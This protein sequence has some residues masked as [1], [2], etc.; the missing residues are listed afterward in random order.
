MEAERIMIYP[1]TN[2]MRLYVEYELADNNAISSLVCFK[3]SGHTGT[4]FNSN[5]GSLIVKDDFL[6]ELD[7]CTTILPAFYDDLPENGEYDFSNHNSR[8]NDLIFSR[9]KIAIEKGKKIIISHDESTWVE[10]IKAVADPEQIISMDKILIRSDISSRRMHIIE[11]PVLFLINSFQGID[12]N[13]ILFSISRE[14]KRI[15]YKSTIVSSL[16][17]PDLFGVYST[18]HIW[19]MNEI[20]D[21]HKII[22]LNN[23]LK[24]IEQINE[25]G[26]LLVSVPGAT[27]PYSHKAGLTFGS[28]LFM[29]ICGAYPDRCT[30]V[31]PF[32]HYNEK[33]LNEWNTYYKA[34]FG[35]GI[36]DYF[37]TA[38]AILP[39][40]T[41]VYKSSQYL[42]IDEQKVNS[43]IEKQCFS[44]PVFSSTKV[45]AYVD[46]LVEDLS[47][48]T[49]IEIV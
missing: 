14:L 24:E 32:A 4:A 46:K 40:A 15:G 20:S 3:G 16:T 31:L 41:E 47:D 26:I 29:M 34:K 9:I 36:S 48:S 8:V 17:H 19:G 35:I 39:N 30:L 38:R 21:N 11:S 10:K 43:Y 49:D 18:K 33:S 5:H 13:E 22:L 28:E 23:Y 12:N 27:A 37:I 42:T 44:A 45:F 2:D 7:N 25:S 1:F 6:S